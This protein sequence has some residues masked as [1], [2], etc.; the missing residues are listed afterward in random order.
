MAGPPYHVPFNA[1]STPGQ[2]ESSRDLYLPYGYAAHQYPPSL[3]AEPSTFS[4]NHLLYN[5]LMQHTSAPVHPS[6]PMPFS[7]A[8]ANSN[9]AS[10]IMIHH[11]SSENNTPSEPSTIGI[12]AILSLYAGDPPIKC[13]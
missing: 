10:H 13:Q 4:E 2:D 1:S 8:H 11:P 6:Y 3:A 9:F 5:T 7:S 12:G